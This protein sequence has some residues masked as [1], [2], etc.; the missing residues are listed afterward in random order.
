MNK[1]QQEAIQL[2]EFAIHCAQKHG[3][4][5]VNVYIQSSENEKLVIT[6]GETE[7]LSYN[8]Q[9]AIII[10]L[11]HNERNNT[12]TCSHLNKEALEQFIINGIN[13][14]KYLAPDPYERQLPK[15]LCYDEGYID[16]GLYDENIDKVDFERQ[17]DICLT[18]QQRIVGSD[19][20]TSS[21]GINK[22]KA[23]KLC[24]FSNGF[25]GISRETI[26]SI[27]TSATISDSNEMRRQH[28]ES[29]TYINGDH[30]G[31]EN[32]GSRT[33]SYARA[34]K[35]AESIEFGRYTTIIHNSIT[36]DILD[37]LISATYGSKIYD[38]HSFLCNKIDKKIT[39]DILTIQCLPRTYGRI[40]AKTFTSDGLPATDMNVITNG[41]LNNYFINYR[42]SLK[43]QMAPTLD[44]PICTTVTPGLRTTSEIISTTRKGILITDFLGGNCNPVSGDFSYGIEG[45]L[46]E[47]GVITKPI[48]EMLITGNILELMQQL[49][50]IG[51]LPHTPG[52]SPYPALVFENATIN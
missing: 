15:N 41:V 22:K 34:K 12:I 42:Y 13:N 25:F 45:F 37:P 26:L 43:M 2:A 24:L 27:Y 47:N 16:L 1:K 32:L 3:A 10:S 48:S 35:G 30:L 21:C 38:K 18:E 20:I 44:L 19:V 7:N 40:G 51:T 29:R 5:Q 4:E 39:S 52:K 6:D 8:E 9:Q 23:E 11:Y 36:P 50:E 46:I 28:Y 49:V 31:A 14:I 33:L 17:K